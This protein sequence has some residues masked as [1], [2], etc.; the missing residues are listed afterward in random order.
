MDKKVLIISYYWPPSGGSGVQRWVKFAKY[1]HQ[2][3][4]KAVVYTPSNPSFTSIDPSLEAEVPSN[5]EVIKK[6]I[7]EPY[8]IYNRLVS[9]RP[10]D[11]QINPITGGKKTWK[12][13]LF[14][15]IRAN[16]FIPDPRITWYL[17]SVS[18]LSKYLKENKI[19][20]IVSTG[21]PH[22]MHLIA[23]SLS[24]KFNIPWIA[25]FRDPWTKIFYFK[26]L[27]LLPFVEKIYHKLE[28]SVLDSASAVVAVSPFVQADFQKMTD[29]PVHLITN[30]Y[31]EED[32]AQLVEEDAYFNI[33]HTG[34][35]VSNGNPK[36]LWDIIAE[37]LQEDSLFARLLRIRLVG[38][39]DKEVLDYLESKNLGQYVVNLG[40]QKHKFAIRELKNASMLILPV[41]QEPETRAILPGKL[42]EYLASSKPILGIGMKDSAMSGLLD[43]Q[44]AGKVFD[45]DDKQGIRDFIDKCFNEFNGFESV[46]RKRDVSAFSRKNLTKKMVE[47]MD[48]L[49]QQS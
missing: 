2:F 47:L 48:S 39:T 1:L 21:P 26:H 13:R 36:V 20:I 11:K 12:E 31:D 33:C 49:I 37:K 8:G 41:R 17:P 4:W 3:S 5:V 40:Y 42:F 46:E 30:G 10:S 22:S 23:K 6:A 15:S 18:Y 32:F 19:D 34:L 14:L 25:D 9:R 38:N 29:T 27:P 7:I 43:E 28:K 24:K 35:L 44:G 45:W 16:L